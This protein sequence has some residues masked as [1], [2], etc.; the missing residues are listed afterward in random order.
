MSPDR[1]HHYID[2]ENLVGRGRLSSRDVALARAR[3]EH[4]VLPRCMDLFTVGCDAAN[5]FPVRDVFPGARVVTGH[6]PDGADLTLIAA[7]EEDVRAGLECPMVTVG[8]GD[9]I[10]SRVLAHLTSMGARI[11]VVGVEG[12]TSGRLK[13]A[14]HA[15]TLLTDVVVPLHE[16]SA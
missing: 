12:H 10:F 3:F 6:G 8:S 13:L 5:V 11:T 1:T 7:I 2:I 4:A 9:H 15:V 16:R 14:A